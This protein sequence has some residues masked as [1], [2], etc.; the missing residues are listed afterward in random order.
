M[1]PRLARFR[2]SAFR[3]ALGAPP[4]VVSHRGHL[5]GRGAGPLENTL[6]AFEQSLDEGVTAFELDVRTSRDGELVVLHDPGLERVTWG[7]D[8]RLAHELD[9]A[10]LT[11]A[12]LGPDGSLRAPRLAS[13]LALARARGASVNVELK[14]DLPDRARLTA[15]AASLA[16]SWDPRHDLVFSSFDPAMIAA[17][18]ALAPEVPRALLV[19]RSWYTEAM[20]EVAMRLSVCAVHLERTLAQPK[21]LARLKALGLAI[22]V[23]TVDDEREARELAALGVDSI[24]SDRPTA[25]A[26][27]LGVPLAARPCEER[28]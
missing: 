14:R 15:R 12:P 22:S 5:A 11:R 28:G 16:A 6:A 3:R 20:L 10:E 1:T 19:H 23:W 2:T 27:A 13:V 9:A 17:F 21:T 25:I 7:R 26:R 4:L 24:I 18:A 8:A